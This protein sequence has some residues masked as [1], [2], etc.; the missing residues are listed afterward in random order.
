MTSSKTCFEVY[1]CKVSIFMFLVTYLFIYLFFHF[2]YYFYY[3][4]QDT[5][6]KDLFFFQCS[7]ER[8]KEE[9]SCHVEFS[10]HTGTMINAIHH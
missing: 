1:Y 9:N 4:E 3:T 2:Y 6:D 8:I 7:I 5:V 10:H